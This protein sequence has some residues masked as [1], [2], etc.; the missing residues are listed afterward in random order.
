[1][2]ASAT[3]ADAH[4]DRDPLGQH[5]TERRRTHYL[6]GAVASV[7]LMRVLALSLVFLGG[8]G[9]ATTA[10]PGREGIQRVFAEVR[11]I[12]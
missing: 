4:D 1:M 7:S 11:G 12:T 6:D 2:A 8:C 10:E 9:P 5:R 3:S